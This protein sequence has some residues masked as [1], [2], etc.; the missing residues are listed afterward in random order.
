[1]RVACCSAAGGGVKAAKSL[2]LKL[3][4]A[5]AHRERQRPGPHFKVFVGV[6]QG[7]KSRWDE[8]RFLLF[9]WKVV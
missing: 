9:T 2:R 1:M 6:S 7:I 4:T 3:P 5:G 8:A